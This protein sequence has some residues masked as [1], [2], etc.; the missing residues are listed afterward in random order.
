MRVSIWKCLCVC[1]EKVQH[2]FEVWIQS[3]NGLCVPANAV[4]GEADCFIRYHFPS[5][6]EESE[7]WHQHY[8]LVL[9][10]SCHTFLPVEL[11]PKQFQT[12]TTLC[13][14]DMLFNYYRRHTFCL[15]SKTLPSDLL[16][17][18]NISRVT[19]EVWAR[20][21]Y[22]N[23]RDQLVSKVIELARLLVKV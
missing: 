15:S 23:V 21:Y 7:G 4:W 16:V 13:T 17:N 19:F 1:V 22:P 20:F 2:V 6:S 5:A 8:G 10:Y 9:S 14:P 18:S 11:S 3:I 12:M